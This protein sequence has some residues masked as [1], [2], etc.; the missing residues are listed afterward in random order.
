MSV[1]PHSHPPAQLLALGLSPQPWSSWLLTAAPARSPHGSLC[2]IPPAP[3]WLWWP[4]AVSAH[5]EP[6]GTPHPVK[7]RQGTGLRPGPSQEPVPPP[8]PWSSA[9]RRGH[10]HL[11]HGRSEGDEPH[12]KWGGGAAAWYPRTLRCPPTGSVLGASG[13]GRDRTDTQVGRGR[14]TSVSQGH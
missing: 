12:A 6:S 7:V 5:S 2:P 10:W 9:M 13:E 11:P 14:P 3:R 1:L 4:P 8:Y